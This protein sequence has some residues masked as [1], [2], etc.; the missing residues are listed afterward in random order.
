MNMRAW[1]VAVGVSLFMAGCASPGPKTGSDV[2]AEQERRAANPD[3]GIY[4]ADC[5]DEFG[6]P[7]RYYPGD[8]RYSYRAYCEGYPATAYEYRRPA[9]VQRPRPVDPQPRPAPLPLP[10]RIGLFPR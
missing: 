9:L 2:V 10:D 4:Y 5:Y 3:A 8:P 1:F 7:V 6:H